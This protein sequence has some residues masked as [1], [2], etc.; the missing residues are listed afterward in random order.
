METAVEKGSRGDL[1]GF[2]R[3]SGALSWQAAS[4]QKCL[5]CLSSVVFHTEFVN[6]QK[7][8]EVG[9]GDGKGQKRREVGKEEPMWS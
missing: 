9:S 4:Q 3:H 8:T 5:V 6:M 7:G 2:W 1:H